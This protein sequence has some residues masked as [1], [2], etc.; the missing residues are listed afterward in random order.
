[1]LTISFTLLH[2][3]H[4]LSLFILKEPMGWGEVYY[5]PPCSDE[6]IET[7]LL[8]NFPKFT[9][10]SEFKHRVTDTE[11]VSPHSTCHKSPRPQG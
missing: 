2:N 11:A 10:T 9:V 8:S 5:C 3:L 4:A 6:K 7:K 1:M